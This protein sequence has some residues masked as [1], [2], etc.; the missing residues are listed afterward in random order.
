ML[1]YFYKVIVKSRV[2]KK[3]E[4]L[5]YYILNIIKSKN[6]MCKFQNQFLLCSCIGN[7][8]E[9]KEDQIDWILRR[10]EQ[11]K[12]SNYKPISIIGQRFL[13]NN[14]SNSNS[15]EYLR[16]K[17]EI[18]EKMNELEEEQNLLSLKKF[19]NTTLFLLSKL[20]SKNCFDKEI[21]IIDKDILS[22]KLDKNINLWVDFIYRK[23]SWKIVKF[24]FNK[25]KYSEI[26]NGKI[27]SA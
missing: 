19:Q 16:L 5:I 9:I 17:K 11:T 12:E 7:N 21:E 1:T 4:L 23:P 13:P 18:I 2:R 20:N 15:S 24:N 14:F 8:D 10:R 3:I 22:I 25:A 6:E 27:Q 26:I